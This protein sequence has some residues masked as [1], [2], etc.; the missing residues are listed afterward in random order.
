[1]EKINHLPKVLSGMFA[2]FEILTLLGAVILAVWAFIPST[3]PSGFQLELPRV[4]LVPE[5][6]A[7]RLQSA[8]APAEVVTVRD[9]QG[10][11]MVDAGSG[12]DGLASRFIHFGLPMVLLYLAFGAVTFDLLRRLFRNVAQRESFTA[13]NIRLVHVL[14]G[15][16][17]VF[18]LLSGVMQQWSS[19]QVVAYLNARAAVAGNP[20]HFETISNLKL[21][22][23][24]RRIAVSIHGT[25]ILAGLLVLALGEVFRQGLVLKQEND[26]TV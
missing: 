3:T 26:L 17:I 22:L 6:G 4:G 24:G 7:L 21:D 13:R 25:G 20:M 10:A 16:I 14:G 8:S 12:S 11:L 5:A 9:L 18:S 1:M 19:S 2:A 15:A 23:D